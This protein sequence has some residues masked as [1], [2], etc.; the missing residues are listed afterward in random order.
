MA[1]VEVEVEVEGGKELGNHNRT[2]LDLGDDHD[3]VGL[4]RYKFGS[5]EVVQS[6]K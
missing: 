5:T 3:A 1:G 4:I 6:I 2:D